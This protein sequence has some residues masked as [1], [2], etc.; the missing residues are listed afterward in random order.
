MAFVLVYSWAEGHT[1]PAE[2]VQADTVLDQVL[3]APADR[4]TELLE[5]AGAGTPVVDD[6]SSGTVLD[7]V[8]EAPADRLAELLE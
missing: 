4:L 6:G 2:V 3:E 1:G 8:I 5:Q 7:Q